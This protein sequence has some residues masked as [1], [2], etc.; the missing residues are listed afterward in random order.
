[1]SPARIGL[2]ASLLLAG[3]GDSLAVR[4]Q[5]VDLRVLG[6]RLDPPSAAPGEDVA[7][8]ALIV[9]RH[10]TGYTQTWYACL[11]PVSPE[12]YLSNSP[13]RSDCPEG[14]SPHGTLLGTDA[15]GSFVVP[16]DFFA[17]VVER[18]AN[19]GLEID[20]ETVGFLIGITGWH[21][22]VTLI[23]EGPDKRIEVQKRLTVTLESGENDNPD[24]PT[25]VVEEVDEDAPAAP[26]VL[27]AAV[28][29]SGGCV[30]PESPVTT[31]SQSV[32]R[33][34]PVNLPDPPV[35]YLAIDFAEGFAERKETHFFSWFS[36]A[37]GLSKP[38]SQ[39]PEEHVISLEIRG[40]EPEHLVPGPGGDPAIPIWIVTRDGRGGT[41]W[42]QDTLPYV[43]PP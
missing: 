10:E 11:A 13:D 36:T 21:L 8:S 4:E 18:V 40:A 7:A 22:R 39:G 31:L 15:A 41:A 1:L 25:I 9:D 19:E 43:A 30:S 29:P 3:C 33:V 37:I 27:T 23:V 32:Y 14:D 34:T 12:A 26:L 38:I 35:S 28:D 17:A 2:I 42:C 20:E 5:V 24:P 16:E 6:V